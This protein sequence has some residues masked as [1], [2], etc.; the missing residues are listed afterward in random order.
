M[1]HMLN[2]GDG[3]KAIYEILKRQI[4]AGELEPGNELKI[5]PLAKE[6]DISIVPLREAIRM[7]AAEKLVELRPRR[8]PIIA[9]L[10]VRDL[11]EM[12]QI[13][14]ALEPII[15]AD[16][17]P[18][19]TDE[20]LKECEKVLKRTTKVK[21]PWEMV[22]LNKDFHLAILGPTRLK[23]SLEIVSDQYDGIARLTQFRVIT[24]EEQLG[25]L[26]DEH[27]GIFEAAKRGDVDAAVS[28]MTHHI[29]QA[30]TR[31][32]NELNSEDQSDDTSGEHAS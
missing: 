27:A 16:A 32:A 29:D 19:H 2:Y 28:E 20:T 11:V 13:R 18:R 15:L 8:S 10:D 17:I 31:A 6:M 14:G 23:R 24:H 5:M 1:K 26:H 4:I 30:T 22:E 21:D 25:K 9:R 12:N 3:P 7:L